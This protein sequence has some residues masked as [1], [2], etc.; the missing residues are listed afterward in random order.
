MERHA[1]HA[2]TDAPASS[3]SPVQDQRLH[4]E[5]D[6][7]LEEPQQEASSSPFCCTFARR[8]QGALPCIFIVI[9]LI[10][11]FFAAFGHKNHDVPGNRRL[12]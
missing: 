8:V 9:A 3:E 11:A 7:S 5:E 1:A 6:E 4:G 2:D 12:R 10:L